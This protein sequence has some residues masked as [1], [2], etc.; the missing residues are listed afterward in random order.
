[1]RHDLWFL[2][3]ATLCLV[4]GVALGMHMGL[5]GDHSLA[6]VHAHLNLLGWASLALFGL[7][8][9][10]YPELGASWTATLHLALCGPS[11]MLV[12]I[13]IAL[14]ILHGAPALAIAASV[15]W[16]A[17]CITFLVKI[18]ILATRHRRRDQR[19]AAG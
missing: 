19:P 9:R 6:P 16:L 15:L 1:M 12:P 3:F 8:Y 13:G 11:A 10:V 14:S 17:G 18:A 4:T 5:A 7:A 2:T